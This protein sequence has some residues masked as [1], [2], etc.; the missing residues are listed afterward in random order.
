MAPFH[1]SFGNSEY[2]VTGLEPNTEYIIGMLTVNP[3][4]CGKP[5]DEL[6]VQTQ[7]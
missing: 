7:G 2:N 4:G 3:G 1:A 5:L 6:V